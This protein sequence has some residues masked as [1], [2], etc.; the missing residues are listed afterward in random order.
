MNWRQRAICRDQD[1]EL[2]FPVG[3]TAPALR[4]AEEAKAVCRRCPAVE[5]CLRWALDNNQELGVW[6]GLSE[7]ER[8]ALKRRE[9]VRRR[10]AAN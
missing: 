8:R 10:A 9:A 5:Q 4:Q 7:P 6:G 2:I 1:P 3:N